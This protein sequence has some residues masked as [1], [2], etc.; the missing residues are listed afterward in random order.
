MARLERYIRPYWGYIFLTVLIKLLGAALELLIPFLMEIIL[1][2]KVPSGNLPDIFRFGGLMV[3]CAGGCLGCNILANRMSAVSSGRITQSIRHDLFRKLQH[4]SARQMDS[5]TV[6]SAESSA[7]AVNTVPVS[8]RATRQTLSN[9]QKNFL[10]L[11]MAA[12]FYI[13]A[14]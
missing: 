2:L 10:H 1:D 4:L 3:L 7:D 6:S 14:L 5:L 13:K 12:A 9:V 8:G 11:V